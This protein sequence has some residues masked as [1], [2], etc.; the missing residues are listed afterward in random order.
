ML[1][2]AALRCATLAAVMGRTEEAAELFDS[3]LAGNCYERTSLVRMAVERWHV[4]HD[5]D[6]LDSLARIVLGR[7]QSGRAG[8]LHIP[9]I[10]S[11]LHRCLISADLRLGVNFS[12]GAGGERND[13]FFAVFE[14]PG[15]GFAWGKTAVLTA[16]RVESSAR[17]R[18]EL[19]AD[20]GPA[21]CERIRQYIRKGVADDCS[22]SRIHEEIKPPPKNKGKSVPSAWGASSTSSVVGEASDAA[23]G[24]G[25]RPSNASLAS[26]TDAEDGVGAHSLP[27][28]APDTPGGSQG[29]ETEEEDTAVA[30]K[31]AMECSSDAMERETGA[32]AVSIADQPALSSASPEPQLAGLKPS[33]RPKLHMPSAE[34]RRKAFDR[35]DC[36]G[37]GGLS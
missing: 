27:A 21:G 7:R 12:S 6:G 33:P 5:R 15:L 25:R 10:I 16:L 36:N 32:Q 34:E 11:E 1:V 8:V 14:A 2:D 29:A 13:Q 24:I 19:E 23:P 9:R 26:S 37:N 3:F 31:V 35:F 18:R 4:G 22:D 28:S 30:D 20:S 17:V